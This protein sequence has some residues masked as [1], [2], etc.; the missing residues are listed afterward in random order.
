MLES[1][2]SGCIT[3][4]SN[5]GGIRESISNG[6]TGFLLDDPNNVDEGVQLITE[7]IDHIERYEA[8][9]NNARKFMV[10][11][12]D[13]NISAAKMERLYFTLCS[14]KAGREGV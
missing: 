5:V 9:K 1:M 8:V 6:T 12:F 3:V 11:N 7:I 10:D 4:S 14:G 13:W 2:A